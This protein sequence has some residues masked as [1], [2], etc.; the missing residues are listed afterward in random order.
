VQKLLGLPFELQVT[1]G[2]VISI[3]TGLLSIQY[4]FQNFYFGW[5]AAKDKTHALFCMLPFFQVLIITWLAFTYSQFWAE[6]SICFIFGV[7]MLIT[8]MTGNLNLKSCAG[9]KY[10]P[11]YIDP[12]IF[13]A[14]LYAD[15]NRLLERQILMAMYCLLV[16]ER[17]IMYFLFV[18]NMVSQLCE[19]L[20]IPF[21][22]VKQ[23]YNK[24]K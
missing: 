19:F 2:L 16:L 18:R 6:Y 20:E 21:I 12:F 7:G 24:T 9:V 10:N 14:I 1:K 4:N 8:N 5:L 23:A 17:I 13:C 11:I 3:A 22:T 15:H